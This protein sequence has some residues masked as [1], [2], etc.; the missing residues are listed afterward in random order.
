MGQMDKSP[1]HVKKIQ[2]FLEKIVDPK[3]GY[4]EIVVHEAAESL[5]NMS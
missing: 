2:E 3:N 4:E 1:E 5:G